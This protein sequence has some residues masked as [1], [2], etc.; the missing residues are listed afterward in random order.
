VMAQV[1][2]VS[3]LVVDVATCAAALRLRSARYAGTVPEPT[4]RLPLGPVIPVTA[5]VIAL[6]ILFGA[7][8]AQLMS[9]GLALAAGAVLFAVAVLA[10][11]RA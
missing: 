11:R 10:G 9:G 5:I 3:R 2:A 6:T 8:P 4:M 7:N 1:S